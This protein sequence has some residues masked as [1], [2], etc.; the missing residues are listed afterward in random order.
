MAGLVIKKKGNTDN[1]KRRSKDDLI[2]RQ[3]PAARL[4]SNDV[5]DEMEMVVPQAEVREIRKAEMLVSR[6]K[7]ILI[8]RML[9]NFRLT[10]LLRKFL[11][12]HCLDS[13]ELRDIGTEL[14]TE[15]L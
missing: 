2:A 7:I 14:W 15:C 4:A 10:M 1:G 3:A 8:L 5:E 9:R 12:D 6:H 13:L 11:S